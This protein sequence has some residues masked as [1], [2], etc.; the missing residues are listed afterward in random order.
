M[1]ADVDVLLYDGVCALCN[2]TVR[3]LV[4]RDRGRRF[5]YAALQSE[6]ARAALAPYGED[7]TELST[8]FLLQHYGRPDQRCC[9]ARERRSPRCDDSAAA[10]LSS[11]A[12][13]RVLPTFLLDAGYRVVARCATGRSAATTSCP[14]PPPSIAISSSTAPRAPSPRLS[15][16]DP[17]GI[18]MSDVYRIFGAELSPVL[19]QGPLL[20]PLQGHPAQWIPRGPKSQEEFS[21][22]A[23]LPLVPLVVTP[24]NEGI[25][26]STPIIEKIE[27]LF[28]EPTIYPDDPG[29]AL[30]LGA[31]RGVRRR[32]GQ[33]AHV[34]LPLV[35]RAGPTL[36]GGAHRAHEPA[37]RRA[38]PRW[39]RRRSPTCASAW[40]RAC[41]SSARRR[42]PRTR[43][44]PRSAGCSGM[45][46]AHLA[47]RPYLLGARPALADFGMYAQL[48]QC[49]TDPTPGAIIRSEAPR[50]KAW[51]DRMLDP[52][53]D[54]AAPTAKFES[55]SS[56][57]ST[58]E[59]MLSREVGAR[60][61]ALD[62][63]ER[64]GAPVGRR[65]R[66]RRARG[67]PLPSGSAEVPRAL[68]R[69][70]ARQVQGHGESRRARSDPALDRLPRR[71]R[72]VKFPDRFLFGASTAA[73]QIEGAFDEDGRGRSI[74]DVF[75]H[76]PGKVAGGDTGDRACDHYHRWK[77]DV[78]AARRRAPRA[79]RFSIAWP[80]VMPDGRGAGQRARARLLRSAGRCAARSRHRALAVPLPLGPA[81]GARGS[82]RLAR[83]RHR[84]AVRRLRDDGDR[85]ASAIA[86]AISSS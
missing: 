79:Y 4:A 38:A 60:L 43:S 18:L 68:A 49:L 54:E 62:A 71:D 21:K 26:D 3:F 85:R 48:Y 58:L 81:A 14:L 65:D 15:F 28:P 7:P 76:T 47:S 64:R 41:R 33:Q 1:P 2:G 44:R 11:R 86:R 83:A 34:P 53:K 10:G 27:T 57:R 23:K 20:L 73:Y 66:Q 51:I 77:E 16:F 17:G 37:R 12:S 69:R 80:R 42:R 59:P 6:F 32:V 70:A 30:H 45:V 39:S 35:L 82:R 36:G 84:L 56:L 67:P 46:E 61:P 9:A 40:C 74:W 19:G 78:R 72:G 13:C 50:T 52:S 24:Q 55:W 5:R 63:G 8:V 25:Q 29:A 22:Y 31:A 75:S